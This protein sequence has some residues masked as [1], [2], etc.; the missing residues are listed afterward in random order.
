MVTRGGLKVKHKSRTFLDHA[1]CLRDS[2]D[3]CMGKVAHV[4]LNKHTFTTG[5]DITIMQNIYGWV[6]KKK[7]EELH[8]QQTQSEAGGEENG[9][10]KPLPEGQ[11]KG[12]II[13]IPWL[14]VVEQHASGA[15]ER[16]HADTMVALHVEFL[17]LLNEK[18]TPE[19][20][21]IAHC[22]MHCKRDHAVI[23]MNM[24]A[25]FYP[26]IMAKSLEICAKTA[27]ILL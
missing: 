21:I 27:N 9:D 1:A 14:D 6:L 26:D 18:P 22:V 24:Y 15:E 19:L 5:S 25:E 20:N 10:V 2:L 16:I 23:E 7:I 8:K 4:K 11:D 3:F 17:K 12:L 13:D